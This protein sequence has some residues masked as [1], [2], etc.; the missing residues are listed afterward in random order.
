MLNKLKYKLF[1][2]FMRAS[3]YNVI[4]VNCTITHAIFLLLF[5]ALKIWPLV[6][7][8]AFSVLFYIACYLFV[9]KHNFWI[10]IISAEI[11]LYVISAYLLLGPNCGF[12]LY[13][14]LLIQ[15]IILV[16]YLINSKIT[17]SYITS[18]ICVTVYMGL[19]LFNSIT[20]PEYIYLSKNETILIHTYNFAIALINS[21][22]ISII[23]TKEIKSKEKGLLNQNK[24]LSKLANYDPLTNLLN[25]RSI[26]D[27]L[28][29]AMDA[30]RRFHID[31]TIAI[32]DID[33][34]KVLNDRFGHDCGDIVLKKI[35]ELI[36]K[37][38]R[39]I[40]YV[41]RWGGEEILIL[42][43]NSKI[44]E[45]QTIIERIHNNMNSIELFYNE[46]K[47]P[48]TMTFG[49]CSS[50]NYY[51]I[52]DIILQA[53]ANMYEGKRNG[54]NCLISTSLT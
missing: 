7:Y 9:N 45:A 48:V 3:I 11:L 27:Y 14:L 6:I 22:F 32:G 33:D 25:R 34:F 5:I 26:N 10:R 39:E 8:N 17:I 35:S 43:S 36:K 1:K 42:F 53:D 38:V 37:N 47:I 18:I 29:V 24:Q 15:A 44:E 50:E 46:E 19:L 20:E 54:K 12:Q 13:L 40:D 4:E 49:I 51:M 52:H 23:F 30:K 21:L 16:E 41:C 31:F 2:L 28:D